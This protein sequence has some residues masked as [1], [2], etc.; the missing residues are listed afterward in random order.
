MSWTKIGPLESMPSGRGVR[1]EVGEH[2][3]ALFRIEDD[4]YAIGDRCSHAEASLAEGELFDTEVECPRHGSSFDL[5]TGQPDSL[6][7]TKPVPTF[8]SKVEDGDVYLLCSDG[9]NSMLTDH[10]IAGFLAEGGPLETTGKN[11]IDAA[12]QRGGN[13]NISV[14]LLRPH[15]ASNSTE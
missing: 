13:D 15:L 9:L 2:R 5:T 14:V 3:V 1:V 4:V 10:E 8:A 11:L 7:A 12:N 6:P